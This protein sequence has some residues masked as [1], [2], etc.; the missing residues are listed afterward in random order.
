LQV[1][2]FEWFCQVIVHSGGQAGF[3]VALQ[4]IGGEGDDGQL[5]SASSWRICRV[6]S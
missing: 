1:G 4:G 6:A 3:A 5:L 2:T